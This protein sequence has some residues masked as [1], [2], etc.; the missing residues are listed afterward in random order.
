M[1]DRSCPGP[2]KIMEFG[3]SM[4]VCKGIVS[5]YE[6]LSERFSLLADMELVDP[7]TMLLWH[8]CVYITISYP[9]LSVL[10]TTAVSELFSCF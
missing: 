6:S 9:E 4:K 7:V 5:V 8:S 2:Q 1:L 10:K 3:C